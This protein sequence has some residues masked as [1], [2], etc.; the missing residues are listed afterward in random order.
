[1]S[2]D[3]LRAR[4]R[5]SSSRPASCWL[6]GGLDLQRSIHL[7]HRVWGRAIRRQLFQYV[8]LKFFQK[9]GRAMYGK[10]GTG[11]LPVHDA[12]TDLSVGLESI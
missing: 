9:Q 5:V 12:Y 7:A 10:K 11:M 6:P 1:M 4:A 3:C 2:V 8:M